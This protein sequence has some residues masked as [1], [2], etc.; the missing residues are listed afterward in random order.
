MDKASFLS[1][2]VSLKR[3]LIA[4]GIVLLIVYISFVMILRLEWRVRNI[5]EF[6]SNKEEI[7]E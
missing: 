2:K 5:T 4:V 3:V 6:F 7:M 1:K